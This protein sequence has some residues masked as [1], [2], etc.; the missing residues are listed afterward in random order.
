[1]TCPTCHDDTT[2]SCSVCRPAPVTTWETTVKPVVNLDHRPFR[3]LKLDASE[4]L[5]TEMA[6]DPTAYTGLFA[7]LAS[8]PQEVTVAPVDPE[9]EA[10]V[11]TANFIREQIR[12]GLPEHL[13]GAFD[14]GELRY[15]LSSFRPTGAIEG[16]VDE[17]TITITPVETK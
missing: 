9:D 14:R 15:H 12:A 17:V 8:F 2:R 13:R 7:E 1:M 5:T 11:N 3:P 4:P 16:E 10:D 6:Y